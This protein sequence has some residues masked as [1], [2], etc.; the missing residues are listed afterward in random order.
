MPFGEGTEAE[1][2]KIMINGEQVDDVVSKQL[3]ASTTETSGVGLVP[4]AGG[5]GDN[6][7]GEEGFDELSQTT[8]HLGL[9]SEQ[10]GTDF[11]MPREKRVAETEQLTAAEVG[12]SGSD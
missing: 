7:T 2:T 8:Y 5:D 4:G 9:S 10:E 6:E 3:P 11:G 1:L 12:L